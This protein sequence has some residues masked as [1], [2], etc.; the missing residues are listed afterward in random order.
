MTIYPRSVV[1]RLAEIASNLAPVIHPPPA[2]PTP[3][4]PTQKNSSRLTP[5]NGDK[6]QNSKDLLE[7]C[8]DFGLR[9]RTID[10][11]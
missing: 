4:L 11:L 6:K 9:I 8:N 7:F 10:K 5:K 1:L 2:F 3:P